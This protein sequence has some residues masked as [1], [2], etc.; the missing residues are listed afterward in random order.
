MASMEESALDSLTDLATRCARIVSAVEKKN[1]ELS[2]ARIEVHNIHAELANAKE[3]T[4]ILF[5]L[6]E[7]MW[8]L[9]A[10]YEQEGGPA[11]RQNLLFESV[12][13]CAIAQLELQSLKIDCEEL[14]Q[15]N[16]QLRE[17]L[18]REDHSGKREGNA[19]GSTL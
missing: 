1:K 19:Y 6:V 4:H 16:G 18:Q 13:D 14:H 3:H 15:E 7:K 8:A 17:L 5:T 2:E 9:L 10:T 12:L 11:S